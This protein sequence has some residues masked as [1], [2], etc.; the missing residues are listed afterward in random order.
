ML[1]YL[2]AKP[3]GKFG[4]HAYEVDEKRSKDRPLFQ[5]YLELYGVPNEM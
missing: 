3:K 1:A 5:R 4:K 2:D